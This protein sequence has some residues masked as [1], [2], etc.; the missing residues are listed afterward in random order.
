MANLY[1][2]PEEV[3]RWFSDYGDLT[4]ILNYDLNEESKVMDIGGFVGV[5]AEKIINKFNP[6]VYIVEPIPLFYDQMISKFKH[7]N[8]V[9]IIPVAIGIENKNGIIYLNGDASSSNLEN[10]SE[11][12]NVQFKTIDSILEDYTIDVIDLL[13]IN[14]EG[15]EYLLLD[16]MLKTKVINK[17]KN[18]QIQFHLGIENAIEKRQ[19]IQ[20]GLIENGFNI[21]YKYDFVWEAWS[22][23]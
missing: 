23:S 22:K 18:I 9:K 6:Y 11:K 1:L 15:D 17:F 10:E 3:Q 4:H 14:I 19:L 21:K 20:K 12:I 2:H 16:Y 13:Q 7:N 5:W 8:K